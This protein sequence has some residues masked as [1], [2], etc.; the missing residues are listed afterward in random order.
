MPQVIALMIAGAG[1]YAGWKWVSRAVSDA[2]EAIKRGEA[3]AKRREA[4]A[5]GGPKDLGAL[6]LDP[7]TGAYRPRAK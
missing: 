4:M 3:E 7:Q 1:L 2:Q 6:E 5:R